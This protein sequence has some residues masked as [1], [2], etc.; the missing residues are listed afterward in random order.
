MLGAGVDEVAVLLNES[1]SVHADNRE[2][3]AVLKAAQEVLRDDIVCARA[4]LFRLEQRVLEAEGLAL[5]RLETT[6]KDKEWRKHW[7]LGQDIPGP[8]PSELQ[9]PVK[10]SLPFLRAAGERDV[11]DFVYAA[12][13]MLEYNYCVVD[14]FHDLSACR[15]MR[16]ELRAM[17]AADQ[18]SPGKLGDPAGG[19]VDPSDTS[20]R[21]DMMVWLEGTEP[22]VTHC[23][24]YMRDRL[25][26]FVQK[27]AAIVEMGSPRHTWH[28]QRRSKMMCTLYPGSGTHYVKHYDN[29]HRAN[30]RVL[31]AILYLN[32]DWTPEDG[33][34]VRLGAPDQ[35]MEDSTRFVSI[36]PLMGRALFFWSDNRCPHEVAPAWSNRYAVTVWYLDDNL[37]GG[38]G[39][40]DTDGDMR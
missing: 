15:L 32:E 39:G 29:P 23:G 24:T 4:R 11:A 13:H 31:T 12:K 37:E 19:L 28:V 2:S 33:G 1:V 10:V 34:C 25:D 20:W 27:L 5:A 18:M 36:A 30:K 22:C 26:V 35:A 14:G 7:V 8:P 9:S 38:D 6:D 21:S 40:G 3:V 17:S 16:D